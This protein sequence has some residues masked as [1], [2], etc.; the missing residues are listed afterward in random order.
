M[1]VLQKQDEEEQE[2]KF[3][4]GGQTEANEIGLQMMFICS[5]NSSSCACKIPWTSWDVNCLAQPV[6]TQLP[7]L[8][9]VKSASLK[10]YMVWSMRK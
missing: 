2:T 5:T 10:L 9:L 6:I 7:L 4:H 8:F 3:G 1:M